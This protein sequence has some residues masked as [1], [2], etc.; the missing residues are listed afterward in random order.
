[1][2]SVADIIA[3]AIIALLS[4]MG[5]GSAGLL[6]VWLTLT[7]DISQIGAQALNLYFFIFSSAASLLVHL[8]KR[9]IFWSAIGFMIAVGG[10]GA[11]AGSLLSAAVD[12]SLLRRL[13]GGMLIFCGSVSLWATLSPILRR[14]YNKNQKITGK[15]S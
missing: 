4:G 8:R 1:M 2:N 14:F 3:G 6:V 12:P 10:T 15:N 9:K 13:F 7:S 11:I 5:V